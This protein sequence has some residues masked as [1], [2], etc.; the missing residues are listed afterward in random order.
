[1]AKKR[2]DI[3]IS[4]QSPE[5]V[6]P[7]VSVVVP[8]YNAS[9]FLTRC[10]DSLKRQTFED[11][12]VVAVNDGSKDNSYEILQQYEAADPRFRI[13]T[14]ANGGASSA[15]TF[16]LGQ[17]RGRYVTFLDSD[18]WLDDDYLEVLTNLIKKTGADIAQSKYYYNESTGGQ[19]VPQ[20][21][22][23]DQLFVT[24][25]DFP[26]T[27]Y[28]KM[29]TG[30]QMNHLWKTLYKAE[31]LNGLSF[32]TALVTGEDLYM[33]VDVFTRA[34]SYAYTNKP[35]YHYFRHTESITGRGLS[36]ATRLNC[37]QVIAKQMTGLLKEWKMDTP[38]IRFLAMSRPYRLFFSKFFRM[39]RNLIMKVTK[40]AD[41]NALAD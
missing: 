8:V 41:S 12:E 32:N 40:K 6:R 28:K 27:V 1:M 39:M 25:A 31:L 24:K 18:D 34:Q 37:N 4:K 10:L 15:R 21:I 13:F 26:K 14:K 29:L 38:Y 20:D 23:P 35:L 9:K 33:N 16:G 11:F 17:M 36:I 5:S 7:M 30:I 22:F 2:E 3:Q 19:Y